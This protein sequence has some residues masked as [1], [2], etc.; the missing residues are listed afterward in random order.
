[1]SVLRPEGKPMRAL[2]VLATDPPHGPSGFYELDVHTRAS[3]RG[4][5]SMWHAALATLVSH[6]WAERHG[7]PGGYRWTITDEGRAELA[8]DHGVSRL[9]AAW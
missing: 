9:P 3:R 6:G 8:Q 7:K 4:G 5:T 1:M 2:R